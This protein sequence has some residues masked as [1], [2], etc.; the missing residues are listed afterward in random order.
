MSLEDLTWAHATQLRLIDIVVR[1]GFVGERL[2]ECL[3]QMT[4]SAVLLEGLIQDQLIHARRRRD[5]DIYCK[6]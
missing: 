2:T 6:P 4:E 1:S 3:T 5:D